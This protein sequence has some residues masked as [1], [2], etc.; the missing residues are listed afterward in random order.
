MA[1]SPLASEASAFPEYYSPIRKELDRNA[2][3]R[4]WERL[5]Y[6]KFRADRLKVALF[7]FGYFLTEEIARAFEAAGHAVVRVRGEKDEKYS[8]VVSR[9]VQTVASDRPDFFLTVNHLGFDTEG[10]MAD[11]FRSIEMPAAVWYVDSPDLVVRD[12]PRNVSALCCVFVWDEMYVE[13][14]RSL[15]FE[16][17][18]HLPL[19][20]DETIF[21]PGC[22][23]AAKKLR[24]GSDVGFVGNSMVLPAKERLDKVPPGLRAAVEKTARL[25][26]GSREIPFRDALAESL[27]EGG[28]AEYEALSGREKSDFE[29]GVLWRATLLYRLACLKA[30]G[31]YRPSVRGDA[32]WEK[33]LDK[34]FRRGPQLNYYREL[35]AFYRA[36]KVNFNA[37]SIQMGTAVNQRVFDVPAC[38]AFLLTDRQASLEELFEVGEEV[39]AYK[40]PEEAADLA[41]FYLRNS[42]AREAVAAKGR[43]RVLREHTYRHRVDRIVRK[44]REFYG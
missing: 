29:A 40:E 41:R 20:A 19:A 24:A 28:A 18:E 32:G 36:C 27:R 31:E 33:L 35:P 25:L 42:A 4:L 22:P 13:S 8:A 37:T 7:D 23:P 10:V 39:I 30:L 17:I 14:L 5:R 9:V 21:R 6:T 44:L 11:L 16:N 12:F 1:V 3:L 2:S 26:S 15:G 43:A 38:G 34:R